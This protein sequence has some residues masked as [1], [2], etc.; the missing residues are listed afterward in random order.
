MFHNLVTNSTP[1]DS[2]LI[3]DRTNLN[4]YQPKKTPFETQWQ[5]LTRDDHE[6]LNMNE[7]TCK[8]VTTTTKKRTSLTPI[9]YRT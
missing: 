4:T 1:D 9:H 3:H 8:D 5:L 2:D 7:P 6:Q